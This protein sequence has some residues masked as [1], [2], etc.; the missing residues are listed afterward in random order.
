MRRICQ[1]LLSAAVAGQIVCGA[2]QAQS[3]EDLVG[4][5]LKR[6]Q[7]GQP[8][9]QQE[10]PPPPGVDQPYQ[11]YPDQPNYDQP[12]DQ[13]YPDQPPPGVPP[14]GQPPSPPLAPVDIPPRPYTPPVVD[15]PPEKPKTA[16]QSEAAATPAPA[17]SP[18]AGETPAPA[19]GT[20]PAPATGEAPAAVPGA[21][22]SVDGQVPPPAPGAELTRDDL[23]P[24]A[25]NAAVYSPEALAVRGAN[26]LIL[27]AQILL[28]RVGASPGA[29][30]GYAG[31]NFSKAIAAVETAVGQPIDGVLDPEIWKVLGGDAAPAVLVQY[32]ITD[33]DLAYPFLSSIPDDYAQQAQLQS[34]GFTSPEEMLAERFHMDEKLLRALNPEANFRAVGTAVWVAAPEGQPVTGQIVRIVAD[35]AQKQVRAYDARNRLVVAYPAT[36]GS[37]DNPSP[38]GDHTVKAVARDPVYYYDPANFVQAGNT[39]KLQLPPGPNNPVGTVWIDLS[40]E[41]YGIH[42]TP[43]PSRIGKTA[44]HGCVRLTNWDAE[45]LAGLV[46]PGVIVS[47]TE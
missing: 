7:G 33:Q 47:F 25:V 27:K 22:V 10:P 39:E 4:D 1:I 18:A 15:E 37:D 41:G 20:A 11:P 13:G 2:A 5:A 9:D 23:R 29:I 42:G 24:D 28:D 12:Y 21:P 16:D 14:V 3:F 26:P 31:G 30:D 45:E 6:L 32:T 36:I 44:S 38:T 19:P 40:E 43:E 34:L 35:K 46:E 17:P 8:T